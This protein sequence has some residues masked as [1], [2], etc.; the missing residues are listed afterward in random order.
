MLAL[1]RAVG[2]GGGKARQKLPAN[3]FRQEN[4]RNQ[5]HA[6]RFRQKKSGNKNHETENTKELAYI[7]WHDL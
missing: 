4:S 6:I 7:T 1:K 2:I 3:D 5:F